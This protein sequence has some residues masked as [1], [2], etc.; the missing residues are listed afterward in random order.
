MRRRDELVL[1]HED[2]LPISKCPVEVVDP[3]LRTKLSGR[4]QNRASVVEVVTIELVDA[5][6]DRT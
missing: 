2:E 1:A 4:P 3:P 6:P 5:H